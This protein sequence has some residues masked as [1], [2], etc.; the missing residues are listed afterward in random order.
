MSM[1]VISEF[2][3]LSWNEALKQLRQLN[4]HDIFAAIACFQDLAK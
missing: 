3:K 1:C 2:M 4:K